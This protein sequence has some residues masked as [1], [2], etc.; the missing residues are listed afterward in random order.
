[1]AILATILMG[2]FGGIL[3]GL[4]GVGGGVVLVPMMV[5]LLGITQHTAQG[6][7]MLVIIPTSL[8]A[9]YQLHKANLVNYRMAVW[10]AAGA[11]AG[12][13]VSANFVQMIPAVELKRI[14]GV[15]IIYSGIRMLLAKPAKSE[16]K[17][18]K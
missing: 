10:L 6:I 8:A 11:I 17:T 13:L 14:F 7:S 18:V 4:L 16:N 5:L 12:A 9:I 1:M 2:L 3:S 15:F